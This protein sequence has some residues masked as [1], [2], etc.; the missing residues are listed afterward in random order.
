LLVALVVVAAM[1]WPLGFHVVGSFA[2][3]VTV[4]LIWVIL[5]VASEAHHMRNV[6][7]E[8]RTLGVRLPRRASRSADVPIWRLVGR[9]RSVF[10]LVI[11]VQQATLDISLLWAHLGAQ[12]WVYAIASVFAGSLAIVTLRRVA[13]RPVVA[14]DPSSLAIDDRLRAIDAFGAACWVCMPA[15]FS[16]ILIFHGHIPQWIVLEGLTGFL[17]A[18]LVRLPVEK[19]MPWRSA[20]PS[21]PP[22]P[23]LGLNL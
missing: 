15:G 10:I 5:F 2:G 4:S 13:A 20:P 21:R 8:E 18:A 9:I 7:R 19:A 14:V 22:A 6:A 1:C 16:N 17:L 12:A 3:F 11:V 23:S